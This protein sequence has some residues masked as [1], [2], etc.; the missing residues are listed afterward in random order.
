M[1]RLSV[2]DVVFVRFPFSDLSDTKMRP[3][4]ILART[5]HDDVILSQITSRPYSDPDAVELSQSSFSDGG[6]NRTSYIRPVKL[7]TANLGIIEKRVAHLFPEIRKAV[8][9][10]IVKIL[11]SEQ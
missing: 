5:L 4:L 6:L 11:S 8:V 10:K 1:E 7:F 9:D 3:A 2:G